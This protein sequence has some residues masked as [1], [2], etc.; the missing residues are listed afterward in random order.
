MPKADIARLIRPRSIA[1]IGSGAWTDAVALGNQVLGYTGKIFRVHPT[2]VSTAGSP[3]YRSVADLPEAPDAAFVAVP[4]HDVPAVA[5]DLA[6]LGAG[7]F[8]CFSAG[9]SEAPGELGVRLTQELVNA[10]GSLPFFGPNCYGYVNYFDRVSMLPDQIVGS[11]TARGVAL[12]CQSGT[13]ALTLTY[14]R[15][16]LPIGLVYSVGNQTRL[17]VEDLIEALC[18]DD[19]VTAFGLYLEGVKDPLR[20]AQAAEAAR[21][22]GK[23][24]ALIKSGRSAL[25][26]RTAHTHT[27]ALTGADQVFDAFCRQ[28]GIA[29]CETLGTLCETLK[30]FHTHGP[31]KGNK[32][33]MMGTSGGDMAMSAD[34]SRFLELDAAPLPEPQAAR[35]QELLTER[36]SIA[37]PLDLH[38]YLWFDP[39]QLRKVFIEAFGAGYDV[40]GLMLDCPPEGEAD[41]S[42]FDAVIDVYI[43]AARHSS[44]KTALISSLPETMGAK[45]RQRCLAGG[46]AP[47]QGLREAMEAFSLAAAVGRRWAMNPQ[48]QL[49]IPTDSVGPS[50]AYSLTEKEAK[51]ALGE[52]GVTIPRGAGATEET[53]AVLAAT[54]GFP[55]VMKVSAA[56]IEHKTEAGGVA[57]NLRSEAEV[58]TAAKRLSALSPALLVEEMIGDAVAEVLVGV[59]LDVQFGQV[60]VIGSGGVFTELMSDSISLLPPWTAQAIEAAVSR[61]GVAK[62]LA[63]FRGRPRG[64]VRALVDLIGAVA[65][66]ASANVESL[67]E[68][69]VNPV[70]VRP[71]GRGAVAVDAMIR[72]KLDQ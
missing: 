7:G 20:F 57:L 6:R 42:S 63:G 54:L 44:T 30:V 38:T 65:R 33:L 3:Y 14:H 69:D 22:A 71:E 21:R 25:A 18:V 53:A 32:T 27:G 1:L 31:L 36:V 5:G 37:N 24:I 16:S 47:L 45:V 62:V 59:I 72:V 64:D 8:V 41:S 52:F 60:L 50:V 29:R 68:L 28:A 19:R 39:P 12:I 2:R 40:T 35:M 70:I 15:R 13:I 23:P 48:V 17:S 43:D 55:V 67:V 56:D 61:L 4:N 66:Y 10:A 51:A 46:V 58:A 49:Q 9:F 34:V 11:A 26:A